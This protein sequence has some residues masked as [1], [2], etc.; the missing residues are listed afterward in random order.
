MINMIDKQSHT[1]E[2]P[3]MIRVFA[4]TINKGNQTAETIGIK[5]NEPTPFLHKHSTGNGGVTDGSL[6]QDETFEYY[7]TFTFA[8]EKDLDS[9]IRKASVSLTWIENQVSKEK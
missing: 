7:F 3:I 6:E 5:F 9:F 2:A 8:N 4:E 1:L